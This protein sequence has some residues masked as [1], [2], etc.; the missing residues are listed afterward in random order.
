MLAGRR[1]RKRPLIYSQAVT[2]VTAWGAGSIPGQEARLTWQDTQ[3][4]MWKASVSRP[5]PVQRPEQTASTSQLELSRYL[6]Q[7]QGLHAAGILSDDEFSAAK[8]RLF[9][10]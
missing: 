9:G 8:G 2:T 6:R 5:G 7:L 10:S 4:V 1:A 3:V